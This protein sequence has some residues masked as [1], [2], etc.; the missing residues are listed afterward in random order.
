VIAEYS[1]T[2]W[3]PSGWYAEVASYGDL[4]LAAVP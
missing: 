1:A 4:L 2:T 3:L